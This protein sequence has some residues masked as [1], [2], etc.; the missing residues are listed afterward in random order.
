M[1]QYVVFAGSLLTESC[2]YLLYFQYNLMALIYDFYYIVFPVQAMYPSSADCKP[3]AYRI[4][5]VCIFSTGHVPL[6]RLLTI[7]CLYFKYSPCIPVEVVCHVLTDYILFVFPVQAMNPASANCQPC[8]YIRATNKSGYISNA[9]AETTGCGLTDCP[10]HVKAQK[11]QRI[12]VT[13]L[14]FSYHNAGTR[15]AA[16]LPAYSGSLASTCQT[17]VHE[18]LA[19]LKVSGNNKKDL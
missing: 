12:K 9:V 18:V 5:I 15:R 14:L 16:D 19:V 13:L 11:G 7:Y 1:V 17:S 10:W 3:C 6:Q 2:E 8:D 4:Y